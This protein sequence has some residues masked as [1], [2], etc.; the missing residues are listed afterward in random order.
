MQAQKVCKYSE[1]LMYSELSEESI[2]LLI[3]IYFYYIV[4]ESEGAYPGRPGLRTQSKF[5]SLS[6][7]FQ[8]GLHMLS[9]SARLLAHAFVT[10]SLVQ[11]LRIFG[12]ELCL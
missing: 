12:P 9:F 3:V 2:P 5:C 8:T 4:T 7:S 10:C 11:I 6:A 1:I